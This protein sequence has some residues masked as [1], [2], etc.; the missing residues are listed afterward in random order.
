MTDRLK[1]IHDIQKKFT[2]E[3]LSHQS[4]ISEIYIDYILALTKKTSSILDHHDW[5]MHVKEHPDSIRDNLLESLVDIV[6][7]AMGLSIINGFDVDEFYEKFLDKSI[8]VQNKF[9]QNILMERIKNS[10][11]DDYNKIAIVDIDGVLSDYPNCFLKYIEDNTGSLFESK[12]DAKK[13]VGNEKYYE[14]K[15]HYRL[16][17]R[18][19]SLPVKEG[20]QEFLNKL[21]NNDYFIIL[22]TSRPYD[23]ISRIYADTIHWLKENDLKYDAIV[24]DEYKAEYI[25]RNLDS[26]NIAFCIDDEWDNAL[27]FANSKYKTF[28]I[29]E[30]ISPADIQRAVQNK[31]KIIFSLEEVEI[32]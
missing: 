30:D 3:F 4:N 10:N 24:W 18:K 21:K 16:S 8:V 14:L 25:L 29:K 32:E 1:E 27:S 22:L 13:S 17:G 31:I 23:K 26:S 12:S 11:P 2:E 28:L 7:Y 6:K 9:N 5:K 15:K 20:A 19:R